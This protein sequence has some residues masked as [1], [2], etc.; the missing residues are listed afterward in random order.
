MAM[1]AGFKVSVNLVDY[2]SEYIP[3]FRDGAGKFEGWSYTVGSPDSEDPMALTT[4][5]VYSKAAASLFA[6]FDAAGRGDGSGDTAVD[7]LVERSR[8]E[9]D[10]DKRRGVAHE[11]QRYLAK[12]MYYTPFPGSSTSLTMAWPV[13]GNYG[14]YHGSNHGPTYHWWIDETQPPLRKA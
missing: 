9:L 11:L 10:V 13:L 5:I 8:A 6:G 3:R 7:S 4:L 1:E 12:A 2:A 14:T